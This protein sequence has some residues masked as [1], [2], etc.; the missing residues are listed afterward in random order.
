EACMRRI[1]PHFVL[2]VWL[3]IPTI[4]MAQTYL[5]SPA[6]KEW[7]TIGGDW[8]HSRYS[9]LTQITPGH[10][11]DLKAAWLHNPRYGI[12]PKD[13]IVGEP[14]VKDGGMF[15]A[16]G[17]DDV[18]AVNAKTGAVLWERRS[19]IDQN[20]STVCCGWANRGVAVAEGK[21]F[22]GQL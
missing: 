19:G 7:L 21:V 17:N 9:T 14:I 8:H 16:T 11:K 3:A 18:V 5:R 15:F 1:L 22:L 20:I 10:V 6:G 4:A 2:L 13:P 12:G